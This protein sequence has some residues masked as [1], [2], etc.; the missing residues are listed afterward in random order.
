MAGRSAWAPRVGLPPC[1]SLLAAPAGR[2][3]PPRLALGQA[4]LEEAE[5]LLLQGLVQAQGLAQVLAQVLAELPRVL[6]PERRRRDSPLAPCAFHRCLPVVLLQVAV[7]QVLP[8]QLLAVLREVLLAV[9][10]A[11]QA[12]EKG[13]PS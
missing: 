4:E 6:A 8:V 5:G 12:V 2:V 13:V 9:Q 3:R 7:R 1:A 10:R 11:P